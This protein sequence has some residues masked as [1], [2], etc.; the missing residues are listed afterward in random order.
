MSREVF[1]VRGVH[2]NFHKKENVRIYL[3]LNEINIAPIAIKIKYNN[4]EKR[5]ENV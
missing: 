4:I 3:A 1:S 5:K 2:S